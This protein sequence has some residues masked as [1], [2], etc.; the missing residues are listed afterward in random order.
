MGKVDC[1]ALLFWTL[2]NVHCMYTIANL[3]FIV[4]ANGE[5]Q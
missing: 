2:S 5:R 4:C 3:W 1:L